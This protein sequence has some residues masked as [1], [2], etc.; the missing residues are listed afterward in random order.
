MWDVW[1]WFE[2]QNVFSCFDRVDDINLCVAAVLTPNKPHKSHKMT[3][4]YIVKEIQKQIDLGFSPT[5]IKEFVIQQGENPEDYNKAFKYL[6]E[7]VRPKGKFIAIGLTLLVI[8]LISILTA[9]SVGGSLDFTFYS[10]GYFKRLEELL[11]KPLFA[12]VCIII[13]IVFLIVRNKIGKKILRVVFFGLL[14]LTSIV[15]IAGQDIICFVLFTIAA[16]IV[17][18]FFKK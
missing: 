9:R 13:G 7:K 6:E 4:P 1:A 17:F 5:E 15:C 18:S 12:V 2:N 3:N 11:F 16:Y 14:I 8:G 10:S